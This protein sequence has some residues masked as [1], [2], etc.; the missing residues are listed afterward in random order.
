MKTYYVAN[1]CTAQI[2][3]LTKP[4]PQL[5]K[6]LFY[7]TLLLKACNNNANNK[8]HQQA[9]NL[10]KKAY[11]PIAP[12]CIPVIL[13]AEAF[14]KPLRKSYP[15]LKMFTFLPSTT[16]TPEVTSLL[17]THAHVVF[18]AMQCLAS[19][20]TLLLL[21]TLSTPGLSWEDELV[22][23]S[24]SRIMQIINFFNC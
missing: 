2:L 8:K 12:L 5:V 22:P 1:Q 3:F 13:L 23:L 15:F 11:Q 7:H 10:K 17:G 21:V 18:G 9:P 20:L 14:K 19:R 24:F 4:H 6:T 16:S